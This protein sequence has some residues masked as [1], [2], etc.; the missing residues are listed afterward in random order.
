MICEP[1]FPERE[2]SQMHYEADL[3]VKIS[4]GH[5]HWQCNS[6]TCTTSPSRRGA[7]RRK[8]PLCS[9]RKRPYGASMA[10]LAGRS[11]V[12][13][14][15]PVGTR[16]PVGAGAG[17]KLVQNALLV[18]PA[19]LSPLSTLAY[20]ILKI[21]LSAACALP[22]STMPSGARH[23]A[24]SPKYVDKLN[25]RHR[26]ERSDCEARQTAMTYSNQRTIHHSYS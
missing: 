19:R 23:S 5:C 3:V 13:A 10:P 15:P 20:N 17:G 11:P 6:A 16:P 24:L 4:S 9:W 22:S 12:G 18:S 8:A 25:N 14:G 1:F 2:K 26:A 21:A 7:E